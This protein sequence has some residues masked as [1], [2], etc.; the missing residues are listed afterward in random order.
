MS[1]HSTAFHP[2]PPRTAPRR[3]G[4]DGTS[5]YLE[6]GEERDPDLLEAWRQGGTSF[7]LSEGET[8]ALDLKL[9]KF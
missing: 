9:S 4:G 5:E 3:H 6:P 8:H 7:T 1:G 2:P